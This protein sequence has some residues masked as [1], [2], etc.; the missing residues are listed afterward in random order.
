MLT[1]TRA[2]SSLLAACLIVLFLRMLLRKRPGEAHFFV[3]EKEPEEPPALGGVYWLF[4][5]MI[6]TFL[7]ADEGSGTVLPVLLLTAAAALL[8]FTD[9]LMTVRS[10]RGEGLPPYIL[11]AGTLVLAVLAG[12]FFSRAGNAGTRLTLPVSGA[13][14][15]LGGWYIPIAAAVVLFRLRNERTLDAV[16]G[17]E[18]VLAGVSSAFWCLFLCLV[19]QTGVSDRIAASE[20]AKGL[21]VFTGASA[22]AMLGLCVMNSDGEKVRPGRCGYLGAGAALALTAVSSGCVLL[23]PLFSLFPVLCVLYAA[24]VRVFGGK[25]KKRAPRHLTGK[26]TELGFSP[27]RI[28]DTVRRITVLGGLIALLIYFL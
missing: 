20:A 9:D 7:F 18:P 28:R 10:E 5:V 24:A 22:G 6:C 25:K 15:S 14:I 2:F 17:T 4:A 23:H 12:L 21:S 1:F 27:A 8:G 13:V 16:R 19:A 26:L 3:S 11:P